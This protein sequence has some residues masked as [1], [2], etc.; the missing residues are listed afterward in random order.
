M[1]TVSKVLGAYKSLTSQLSEISAYFKHDS[2]R[3]KCC[4]V[5]T[6]SYLCSQTT[7]IHDSFHLWYNKIQARPCVEG[8]E[9]V[10]DGSMQDNS[11]ALGDEFL[12]KTESLVEALLL[13]VQNVMKVRQLSAQDGAK[14]DDAEKSEDLEG[15]RLYCFFLGGLY[16]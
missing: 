3:D 14:G 4:L 13:S 6:F 5:S 7:S 2:T 1:D 12:S 16:Y 15:R 9:A 11:T 10:A 8:S